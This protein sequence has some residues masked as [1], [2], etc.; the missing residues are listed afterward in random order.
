M[1]NGRPNDER[2]FV[3]KRLIKFGLNVAGAT[4][5]PGISQ[6]ARLARS[7]LKGGSRNQQFTNARA[8]QLARGRQSRFSFPTSLVPKGPGGILGLLPGVPGGVSGFAQDPTGTALATCGAKSVVTLPDGSTVVV[9]KPKPTHLN[10]SGYYVQAVPGQPEAGGVWVAPG[11]TCVANRRRNN[12]NGR[13]NSRA[14]SRLTGWA[15]T[16]KRLRKSVKALEVAS[17]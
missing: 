7:F 3:H 11:T 4:G 17:R 2:G 1:G 5:I 8:A 15:R 12:F 6:G 10:K 16:T 13:A 9:R 14:L